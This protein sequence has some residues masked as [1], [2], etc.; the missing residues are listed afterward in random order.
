[1]W[2]CGIDVCFMVPGTSFCLGFLWCKFSLWDSVWWRITNLQTIHWKRSRPFKEKNTSCWKSII[3]SQHLLFSLLS[4]H[5][6]PHSP[7]IQ[8]QYPIQITSEWV[9]SSLLF[10]RTPHFLCFSLQKSSRCVQNEN[11]ELNKQNPVSSF[12]FTTIEE[13]SNSSTTNKS[14]EE[15]EK[16]MRSGACQWMSKKNWESIMENIVRRVEEEWLEFFEKGFSSRDFQISRT[17]F[18]FQFLHLSVLY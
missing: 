1:M 12:V 14:K 15:K 13:I 16:K 18:H 7:H 4:S 3:H 9:S 17:L 6:Y 5:F 8:Q 11:P 10:F 2:L